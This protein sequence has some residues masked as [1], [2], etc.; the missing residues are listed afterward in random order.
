MMKSFPRK[1]TRIVGHFVLSLLLLSCA[2][3]GDPSLIRRGDRFQTDLLVQRRQHLDPGQVQGEPAIVYNSD[4]GQYQVFYSRQ[5]GA[6]E[7]SSPE[8]P[9]TPEMPE[10]SRLPS[11]THATTPIPPHSNT[12]MTFSL[13][14]RIHVAT[15]SEQGLPHMHPWRELRPT[16]TGQPVQY[17][18]SIDET[19]PSAAYGNRTTLVVYI[20]NGRTLKGYFWDH[21][22]D[23]DRNAELR[24]S[25]VI[26]EDSGLKSRPRVVFQQDHPSSS[27]SGSWRVFWTNQTQEGR[28]FRLKSRLVGHHPSEDRPMPQEVQRHDLLT[29]S[30]YY[31]V[32]S[33][34]YYAL[35]ALLTPQTNRSDRPQ[36][37]TLLFGPT[38]ML[39]VEERNQETDRYTGPIRVAAGAR[40]DSVH[41]RESHFLVALRHAITHPRGNIT[42]IQG[43]KVVTLEQSG[44]GSIS[45][46][47]ATQLTSIPAGRFPYFDLSYD[48]DHSEYR[49]TANSDRIRGFHIESLRVDA[50]GRSVPESE[51]WRGVSDR[52]PFTH[53]LDLLVTDADR[54]T[55]LATATP[56]SGCDIGL[57]LFLEDRQITL[58]SF[59]RSRSRFNRTPVDNGLVRPDAI[60]TSI[61]RTTD[62]PYIPFNQTVTVI[63]DM[64]VFHTGRISG[65]SELALQVRVQDAR[66][67]IRIH[68]S[69]L[70]RGDGVRA[71]IDFNSGWTAGRSSWEWRV[72]DS[73]GRTAPSATGEWAEGG[74]FEVVR[75][76]RGDV[77]RD[78]RIDVTDA[79]NILTY[80]YMGSM[81]P[82][83]DRIA[84]DVNADG[85]V[86]LTDCVYL[87]NWLFRGG[88]MALPMP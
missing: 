77:N 67:V 42:Q 16:L 56:A 14:H 70:D 33:N 3:S 11:S 36:L 12:R 50:N 62:A 13:L 63:A 28:P 1:Q 15:I 6:T 86:T 53:L 82:R 2:L 61:R 4:L 7:M 72:V 84:A 68:E 80:L 29:G 24:E 46:G 85:N 54:V 9:S 40:N 65:A 76:L 60:P 87:L 48:A 59:R 39:A 27:R 73:R 41:R 10:W 8:S 69:A 25:F 79:L 75:A 64:P 49:L 23:R 26:S 35:A 51:E 20:E 18:E 66:G 21:P 19:Q 47:N 83:F 55:C 5:I 52:R 37:K 30:I 17:R 32:A 71:R 45:I 88:P 58:Q 43:H 31:D 44:R 81:H 38:E 22:M 57:L 74:S 34:G 78:G